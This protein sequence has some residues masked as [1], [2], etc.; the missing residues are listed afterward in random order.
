M[1]ITRKV[2]G[3]WGVKEVPMPE[4]KK[5][6]TTP[7]TVNGYSQ[8]VEKSGDII[9]TQIF[10]DNAL[11]TG[12]A[13]IVESLPKG[14]ELT[15]VIKSTNKKTENTL[16]LPAKKGEHVANGNYEVKRGDR[17][18]IAVEYDKTPPEGVWVTLH[19]AI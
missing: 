18:S 10:F 6:Q 19:G 4:K 8:L 11:I 17:V 9:G 1:K 5:K 2:D 15:I 16:R 12:I 14:E 7:I 3:K 13:I